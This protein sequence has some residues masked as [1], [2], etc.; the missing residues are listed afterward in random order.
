MNNPTK[1]QVQRFMAKL[2]GYKRKHSA[3]KGREYWLYPDG[4]QHNSLPNWPG[5]RKESYEL[6]TKLKGFFR[7]AYR[8]V[9]L[10]YLVEL[11]GLPLDPAW[12]ECLVWIYSEHGYKWV[13]CGDCDDEGWQ[14]GCTEENESHPCDTCSGQGGEFRKVG[15]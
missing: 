7:K 10:E 5:D 11:T 3:G 12:F 14:H 15:G 9:E 1:D 13:E 8:E 2:L 4:S 6:P